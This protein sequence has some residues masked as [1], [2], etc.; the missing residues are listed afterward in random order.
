MGR[1]PVRWLDQP[2]VER[3]LAAQVGLGQRRPAER[4][5]GLIANEDD[6]VAVTLLTQCLGR[7]PAGEPGADDDDAAQNRVIRT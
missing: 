4:N 1:V 3:L 5:P 6:F 2:S 7:V